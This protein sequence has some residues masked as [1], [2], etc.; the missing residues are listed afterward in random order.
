MQLPRLDGR[1]YFIIGCAV[2]LSGCNTRSDEVRAKEV[3]HARAIAALYFR[4]TSL[5]GRPPENEQEFKE[6]VSQGQMDLNVLGVDSVDELFVSDR[7]GQPLVI[8]YGKTPQGVARGVIGYEQTGKDGVRLVAL[9]NGQVV[10]A[11]GAKFAELV[12]GK[13]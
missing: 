2:L 13:P 8:V 12:K 3:S 11:D 7:D 5:L 6:A 1:I 4:A 9:N 10:E